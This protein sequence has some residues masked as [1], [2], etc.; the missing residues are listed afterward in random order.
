MAAE[1]A[2]LQSDNVSVEFDSR[3]GR[4]GLTVGGFAL[5]GLGAAVEVP[6]RV[7]SAAEM[8]WQVV[9]Q[10]EGG[11][12]VSGSADGLTLHLAFSA[13]C[14]Q[15]AGRA[16]PTLELQARVSGEKPFSLERIVFF[17]SGSAEAPEWIYSLPRDRSL[18][19][20]VRASDGVSFASKSVTGWTKA[21]Q[22]LFFTFPLRQ[23]LLCSLEGRV[24]EDQVVGLTAE[25]VVGLDKVS[26]V[27]ASPL[28]LCVTDAPHDYLDA[29]GERQ[30]ENTM[31]PLA[32]RPV[33]WN[34]W[35]YI[36]DIVSED[37]V[38][39]NL[40]V[41]ANDPV[42]SKHVEYIVIDSGWEHRYGDWVPN[43]RFPHGMEWLAQQIIA[44]GFKAGL[45]LAPPILENCS[46][47]ALWNTELLAHGRAGV[48]CQA[49]ECMRRYG[50]VLDIKK[51]E[52]RQWLRDVFARYRAM[53]YTYFKTDFLRHIKNAVFFNGERAPKGD[54]VREVLEVV[55]EAI[56]P[57]CHLVG[58]NY[59]HETGSGLVNSNR[60]SGD[61]APHWETVRLN[62]RSQG[63]QYWMHQRVWCNDPDFAVC[64]GPET[65]VDP[66]M[67]RM[68]AGDI[69]QRPEKT[70]VERP[71]FLSEVEAR[72]LLG[73]VIL[74]GG[75]VTLSD[76][77]PVLNETGLAL[78]R[79]TVSAQPGECMRPLDLF[80]SEVPSLW[81]Q[82]L[83]D[84]GMRLGVVN[85]S[86]APVTRMV[87][88]STLTGRAWA[89][90]SDFWSGEPIA[91]ATTVTLDLAPHEMRLL[92]LHA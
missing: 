54:L 21:G 73:L 9:S 46:V 61:I 11:L 78:L 71:P 55:R 56:G 91:P 67:N 75:S 27:A 37:Y 31:P 64:R 49:Y 19:G 24:E 35:D 13:K 53:G 4:F 3:S 40:D 80:D 79:K 65:S 14:A 44:R 87:D 15:V 66:D 58:C 26:E 50:F 39:R 83:G 51:P 20:T 82:H 63:A 33:A 32:P 85:W 8:R 5:A 29:H 89:G 6:E 92:V 12:A 70:H 62:A 7:I 10:T 45:W 76:N 69:Y 17:Q 36:R 81:L 41:I 43:A 68:H 84:R 42:L 72:T 88:L 28:S 2:T 47:P 34:S 18:T 25:C 30:R 77:L 59:P 22:T 48:P 74:T 16:L 23:S 57:D 90:I 52:A 1:K 60:I 38:L 86:D